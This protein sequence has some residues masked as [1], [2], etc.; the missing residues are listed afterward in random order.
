MAAECVSAEEY[1]VS[2]QQQ[3]SNA[4][5]KMFCS[6]GIGEPHR[7]PCIVRKKDQKEDREIKKIAMHVLDYQRKRSLAAISLSRLAHRTARR[8]GPERLVVSAPVV[9]AGE[10][11][12]CRK[13]QDYERRREW[14][15]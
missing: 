4:D 6:S 7:L 14:Q 13:R 9:V 5:A 12:S 11:K 1:Y 2:G 3:C 15:K 10:T 8:I